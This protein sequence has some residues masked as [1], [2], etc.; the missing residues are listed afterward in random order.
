ML[1]FSAIAGLLTV[2][3]TA[4]LGFA[5]SFSIDPVQSAVFV[6]PVEEVTTTVEGPAPTTLQSRGPGTSANAS[7]G[8]PGPGELASVSVQPVAVAPVPTYLGETCADF[9]PAGARW[10]EYRLRVSGQ[11]ENGVYA[12]SPS[13]AVSV[14]NATAF[15]FDWSALTRVEAV[16][17]QSSSGFGNLYRYVP[18]ALAGAGLASPSLV[19]AISEVTFCVEAI[20]QPTDAGGSAT[21]PALND[22]TEPVIDAPDQAPAPNPK[23]DTFYAFAG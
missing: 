21:G 16:M 18:A 6:V 8:Q 9:E 1:R 15:G 13:F 23:S 2:A 5:A 20:A 14:S 3:F 11:L 19:S 22:E 12:L 17:V 7:V 4:M 10:S